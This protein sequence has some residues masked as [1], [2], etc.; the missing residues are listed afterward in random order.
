[1]RVIGLMSGTSMD[2]VDIALIETDGVSI[3]KV[4][5]SGYRAYDIAE[6]TTIAAALDQAAALS[7]RDARPSALVA[8][9]RLVTEAHI[10]VVSDFLNH[11]AIDANSV[12]AIGFHGQT[13]FHA[14]ERG[15]TIQLG[16]GAVLADA[17]GIDV[18]YDFRAA[19]MA[20][21]GQGA[22]FV[23]VYH[24]ALASYLDLDL[25]VAFANIGGVANITV[26]RADADP[27]AFDTGPG[28]AMLD[29]WVLA[30]TGQAYDEGG[31]L[32]ASGQ[33]DSAALTALMSDAYFAV[34]F[35]KSLDRRHFSA[36]PVEGLSPA[37]GAA[38]LT[39]FTAES[40]ALALRQATPERV[41]RLIVVGGGAR[42]PTILAALQERL[43]AEVTTLDAIGAAKSL[44]SD[45][46]EAQAF[47]Y[48]ASRKLTGQP[49]TFPTTTGVS[50]PVVG[51]VIVRP[52]I[53][54]A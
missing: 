11:Y 25:P 10:A 33:A 15:L 6:R 53:Q 22:P 47:A 27:I 29:D 49:A 36:Q 42:N 37:D 32:S 30:K 12:A 5:P 50:H 35:P 28:N 44:T 2:G 54:A 8:A 13:V 4:G 48:L 26:V 1:M 41:S 19:D 7:D 31:A 51:G 20:A 23:P 43:A 38:T 40:L 18:V 24:Q 45:A 34:L 52:K 39:A 14:P 46:V 9:E 17:V 16:D 21:G 3:T